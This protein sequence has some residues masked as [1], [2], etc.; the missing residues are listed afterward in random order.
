MT[1]TTNPAKPRA[2]R[3]ASAAPKKTRY[4]SINLD[5]ELAALEGL[6]FRERWAYLCCKR[7]ANFKTGV[8]GAFGNQKLTYGDIAAM[9][10]APATQGRGDGAIDDTQAADFI[11]RMAAVGLVSNIGRRDNG[12]LRFE[13]PLSPIGGKKTSPIPQTTGKMPEI[14]PEEAPLQTAANA[15]LVRAGDESGDELSVVINTKRNINIDGAA[16]S[17]DAAAPRRADGAAPSGEFLAGIAAATAPLTADDIR[18][19]VGG[20]W[21]FADAH[22]PQALKLYESWAVAGIT[23]DELQAAMTSVEEDGDCPDPRPAD[24]HGRLWPVVVAHSIGRLAA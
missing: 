16:A 5:D 15:A 4:I 9:V 20:N 11:K 23:L 2:T 6:G 17:I 13:L 7:L 22:E 3:A 18:K 21:N 14:F 10:K 19:A 1:K 8:V 12:G 24:L